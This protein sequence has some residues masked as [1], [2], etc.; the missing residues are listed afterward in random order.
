MIEPIGLVNACNPEQAAR[1]ALDVGRIKDVLGAAGNYALEVSAG[2]AAGV[3]EA[4][5]T[6]TRPREPV[7]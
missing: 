1:D 7:Q 4:M 3:A 5:H 6:Q 2:V